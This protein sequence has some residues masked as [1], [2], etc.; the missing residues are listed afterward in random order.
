MSTY[1]IEKHEF[2]L[3]DDVL[4]EDFAT[5]PKKYPSKPTT[6]IGNGE[7]AYMEDED[8]VYVNKSTADAPNWQLMGGGGVENPLSENFDAGN[9]NIIN[10]NKLQFGT[11]D[12]T[13]SKDTNGNIVFTIPEGQK[14]ILETVSVE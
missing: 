5:I 6:S 12:C 4:L 2:Y 1:P 13:I 11:S 8:E 7:V 14:I 3:P 9:N 10:I